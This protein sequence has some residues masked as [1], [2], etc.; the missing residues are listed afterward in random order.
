VKSFQ[1]T[2]KTRIGLHARPASRLITTARSYQSKITIEKEHKIADPKSLMSVLALNVTQ[3]DR[4]TVTAEG[5][6][7][8]EAI[9]GMEAFM[10]ENL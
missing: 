4:I 8:D 9:A 1:Y 10:R 7:E 3:N 2:V 6:D 5:A